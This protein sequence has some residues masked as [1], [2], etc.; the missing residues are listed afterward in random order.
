MESKSKTEINS[1]VGKER[2]NLK[3][4]FLNISIKLTKQTFY[5]HKGGQFNCRFLTF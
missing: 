2:I 1:C 3:F 4:F 5:F